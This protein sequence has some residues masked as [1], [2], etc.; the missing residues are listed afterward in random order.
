MHNDDGTIFQLSYAHLSQASL[1]TSYREW[2]LNTAFLLYHVWVKIAFGVNVVVGVT[3]KSSHFIQKAFEYVCTTQYKH[4]KKCSQFILYSYVIYILWLL[5]IRHYILNGIIGYISAI[6]LN[7]KYHSCKKRVKQTN[8][9]NQAFFILQVLLINH[10]DKEC[11]TFIDGDWNTSIFFRQVLL[12][13]YIIMSQ[14][15]QDILF[16]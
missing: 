12:V 16:H 10:T 5:F 11:I 7:K 15:W 8:C 9:M 6:C 4:P 3:L 1:S 14:I 2:Y 13:S